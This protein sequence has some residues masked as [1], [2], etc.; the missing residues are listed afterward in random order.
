MGQGKGSCTDSKLVI[1]IVVGHGLTMMKHSLKALPIYLSK[2][3]I[4]LQ[5]NSYNVQNIAVTKF[6]KSY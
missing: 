5:T 3:F 2:C 4:V 6:P 1:G